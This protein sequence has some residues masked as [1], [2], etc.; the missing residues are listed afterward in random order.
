MNPMN[1][2]RFLIMQVMSVSSATVFCS[3]SAS[4][5]AWARKAL[6]APESVNMV[7]SVP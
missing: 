3:Y 5:R 2:L 7:P 6:K 4:V 1:W